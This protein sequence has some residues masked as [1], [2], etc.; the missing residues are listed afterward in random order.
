MARRRRASPRDA[1]ES[2]YLASRIQDARR[3]G[4]STQVIA[5]SFGMNERTVRKILSGETSG[6]RIY[7]RHVEPVAPKASPSI[8]RVDVNIGTDASGDPVVRTIN[9]KVPTLPT[10]KG[11][12]GAPTPFDVFRLPN[13]QQVAIAEGKRMQREYAALLTGLN[14]NPSIS[15][16]RPITQR[17]PK[18]KL[19]TI[20][21]VTRE[22]IS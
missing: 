1:D 19:H 12:R 17:N 4:Y 13:L 22:A 16:I 9:A 3:R 8:V 7:K 11:A 6:S 21:G 15:T 10:A 5:D 20:T 14:V 18:T 2:R